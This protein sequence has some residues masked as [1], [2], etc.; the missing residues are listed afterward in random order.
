MQDSQTNMLSNRN[1]ELKSC[2]DKDIVKSNIFHHLNSSQDL[3]SQLKALRG[4]QQQST[5]FKKYEIDMTELYQTMK[6]EIEQKT[7]VEDQESKQQHTL[8]V[9]KIQKLKHLVPE[10]DLAHGKNIYSLK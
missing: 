4:G 7:E 5:F 8:F 6:E 1:Q 9:T 3:N 2:I 10:M